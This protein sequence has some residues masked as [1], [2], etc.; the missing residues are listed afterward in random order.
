MAGCGRTSW[1]TSLRPAPPPC[2]RSRLPPPKPFHPLAP[3][4]E[5]LTWVEGDLRGR[6]SPF[7]STPP[8]ISEGPE[9]DIPTMA[10]APPALLRVPRSSPSTTPAP[11][12]AVSISLPTAAS[13]TAR[14]ATWALASSPCPMQQ[15]PSGCR[16]STQYRA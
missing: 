10:R 13:S 1:S 8:F 7:I 2:S 5:K 15:W 4:G 16:L 9:R 3:S 11:L 6:G 14:G 12:R